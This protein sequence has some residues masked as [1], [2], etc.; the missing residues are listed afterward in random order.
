MVTDAACQQAKEG[1]PIPLLPFGSDLPLRKR[2]FVP[3]AVWHPAKMHLLLLQYIVDRYTSPGDVLCDP[4]AGSGSILLAALS[5]RD[6]IA[7]DLEPHWVALMHRN[8]ER[9]S[10]QA[11]L[12]AGKMVIEQAD[13]MQPW[14]LHIKVD[15]V[16][17]S[18]PYGCEM[19]AS[20][21]AKKTLPYRLSRLSHDERWD[22]YLSNP[23]GGTASMLTFHYGTSA[24]QIGSWRG[25]RYWKAMHAVYEH[26]YD[27]IRPGGKLLLVL[28]DHIKDGQRVPTATLTIALC[29]HL[30][31]QLAERFQRLVHP[32]S[33]W[34]RR[35]KEQGLPVVEEEDVL[36]F[37]K[38]GEPE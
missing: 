12:F 28:K 26:A 15:A 36:I 37:K 27:A 9:I 31:F 34:Q 35:R 7:R 33:L 18:P 20:P 38:E 8:A 10:E 3:E 2:F 23:N 11:G 6:V 32:L 21:H 25:K 14:D 19:S 29:R 4:M 17:C 5:G 16:I 24:G 13:A 30:G 22:R 1:S